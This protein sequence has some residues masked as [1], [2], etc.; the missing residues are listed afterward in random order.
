MTKERL[1]L[2]CPNCLNNDHQWKEAY[3]GGT[4]LQRIDKN[5]IAWCGKD[6][7]FVLSSSL[8][9]EFTVDKEN[10]KTDLEHFR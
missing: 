2:S 4:F 6:Q 9:D 5:Y 3:Y 8:V 7:K 1:M 10:E